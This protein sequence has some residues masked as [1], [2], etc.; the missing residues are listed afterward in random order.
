MQTIRIGTRQSDL[1]LT[2]AREV[3]QKFAC[4]SLPSEIVTVP[5]NGDVDL[6][7]PL[8]EMGI[9]GIFTKTLDVALLQ[10]KIDVAVHS[11][12]DIPTIMARGLTLAAVLE[13]APAHDML[14]LSGSCDELN[15][16]EKCIIATGSLRRKA[17]W[18]YRYPNHQVL[19]IRGNIKTR[20]EK[21]DTNNWHGTIMAEAALTRLDIR[22]H[23]QIRLNWMVPAPAQGAVAVV[24]RSDD[25]AVL[26][27]CNSIH[28]F[29][30]GICVFAERQFLNALHGGCSAPIAAHAVI[31]NGKMIFQ[32]NALSADARHRVEVTLE[33]EPDQFS[34]AGKLAADKMMEYGAE[35][36]IKSFH[37]S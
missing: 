17:Q 7:T 8:Y 18:I 22:S 6:E 33:F 3:Q 26:E 4:M 16:S 32:G 20:L 14:V 35:Q 13:R 28:H 37:L 29:N 30:S 25:F 23:K 21:L 9:Q 27:Y 31:Q 24:A 1:A 11:A 36:I 2:Q 12:K 34:V 19:N 10:K 5:S 15:T